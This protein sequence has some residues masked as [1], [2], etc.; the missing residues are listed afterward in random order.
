MSA[1]N[2][3]PILL[4]DDEPEMLHSLKGLLRREFV[5]YT[6]ESGRAALEILQ[7]H[8]IHVVMTDQRMP[9]MTGMQLLGHVQ[10]AYPDALRIVFTGYAD[11][12]AVVDGINHVGLYRYLTKPWDPDE[13]IAVLHQAAA[14]YDELAERARLLADLHEYLAREQVSLQ[15]LREQPT[16]TGTAPVDWEQLAQAGKQLLQRLDG[17]T[18]AGR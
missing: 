8:A 9:E 4:V 5:L 14:R 3:H 2:Q 16:I 1:S 17:V 10:D 15:S 18:R 12:K 6:A 11:I 7:Q 13:L